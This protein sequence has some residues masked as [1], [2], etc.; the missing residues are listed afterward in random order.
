[1]ECFGEN[2]HEKGKPKW[3]SVKMV[4]RVREPHLRS[5]TCETNI[6]ITTWLCQF[7]L[8]HVG[9][10][11]ANRHRVPAL[12]CFH[13]S[14]IKSA[15]AWIKN[16][17]LR[18]QTAPANVNGPVPAALRPPTRNLILTLPVDLSAYC[19]GTADMSATSKDIDTPSFVLCAA[20]SVKR[21]ILPSPKEDDA[22]FPHT[23]THKCS[24]TTP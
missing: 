24:C 6:I 16:G 13:L 3:V 5:L 17:P 2:N 1:M 23:D 7:A 10:L 8:Q 15:L 20:H 19:C 11:L 18:H 22:C 21:R 14:T 4:S 12:F 9:T